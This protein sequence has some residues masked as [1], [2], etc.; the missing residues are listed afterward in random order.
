VTIPM[1]PSCPHLTKMA[2][3]SHPERVGICR[4]CCVGCVDAE[5]MFTQTGKP[6]WPGCA[7][8]KCKT[9]AV[10]EGTSC[11]SPDQ[12]GPPLTKET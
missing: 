12:P 2:G 6:T 11:P 9:A 8:D 4:D 5:P 10:H 1:Y 7:L 3:C